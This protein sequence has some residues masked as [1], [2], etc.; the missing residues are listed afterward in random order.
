M[1]MLVYKGYKLFI[2]NCMEKIKISHF[3]KISFNINSSMGEINYK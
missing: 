3:T 1:S 2:E